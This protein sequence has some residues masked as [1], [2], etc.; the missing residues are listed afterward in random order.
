M[1][2]SSLGTRLRLAIQSIT[3]VFPVLK[4]SVVWHVILLAMIRRIALWPI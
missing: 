4:T 2:H 1:L 3:M